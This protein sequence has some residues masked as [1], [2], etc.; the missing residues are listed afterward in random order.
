[1]TT[2]SNDIPCRIDRRADY[3]GSR[4]S[5]LDQAEFDKYATG[6]DGLSPSTNSNGTRNQSE[7][8]PLKRRR[9]RKRRR[10]ERTNNIRI[11]TINVR[12]LQDELKV[13]TAIQAAE[14]N[15]IDILAL[16]EVR[17]T[18]C[19]CI[20]FD[21]RSL[22]GWQMAWSG[23]A[24]KHIH[25]VAILCAPHVQVEEHQEHMPARILSVRVSVKGKKMMILNCYAPTDST[26]SDTAKNY[27]YKVLQKAKEDLDK[28]PKFKM[29]TLG[30]FNATI[31][32]GSKESGSWNNILGHNN[33]DR[34]ETNG[35]GDHLLQWCSRNQV[36]LVIQK[37]ENSPGNLA[38]LY[39]KKLEED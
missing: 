13:A 26:K 14:K 10:E 21:D 37:Q 23:H 31:G 35:N 33:S 9:S 6:C 36:K 16:Q 20:T 18:G 5:V 19:G 28:Y 38:E 17:H 24:V 4:P 1:M 32:A 29:I 8:C 15:Q 30:D 3:Q 25:G 27:F 34:R 11:A 12:T 7:D 2:H 39:Y 22:K